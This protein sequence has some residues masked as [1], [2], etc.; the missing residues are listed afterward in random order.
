MHIPKFPFPVEIV[1]VPLE[2]LEK[3]HS[4][5]ERELERDYKKSAVSKGRKLYSAAI[6]SFSLVGEE[7]HGVVIDG[8]E[9][10]VD[11]N[12]PVFDWDGGYSSIRC[13]CQDD[14]LQIDSQRC[15]HMDDPISFIFHHF[16]SFRTNEKRL[17]KARGLLPG[18]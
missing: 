13:S 15:Q 7:G 16:S 9:C 18:F 2:S 10:R 14:F 1:D 4:L 5:L 12:L 3:L 6:R 11:L 8:E 17:R